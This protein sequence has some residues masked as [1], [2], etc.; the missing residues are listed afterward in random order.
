[1][2]AGGDFRVLVVKTRSAFLGRIPHPSEALS[3]HV[4]IHFFLTETDRLFTMVMHG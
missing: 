2:P 1:M 3:N 4:F